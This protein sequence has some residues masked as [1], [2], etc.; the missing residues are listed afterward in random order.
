MSISMVWKEQNS[1]SRSS[2]FT[3]HMTF[4]SQQPVLVKQHV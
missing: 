2:M 4:L 1:L 3:G